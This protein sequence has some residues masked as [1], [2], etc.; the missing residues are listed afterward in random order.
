MQKYYT[1]GNSSNVSFGVLSQA[2]I[3]NG[4]LYVTGSV[5]SLTSGV[6][7]LRTAD[8]SL[9]LLRT[10]MG[11]LCMLDHTSKVVSAPT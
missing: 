11:V 3:G 2:S 9:P 8:S 10:V 7:P 5:L 4:L 6:I 1:L